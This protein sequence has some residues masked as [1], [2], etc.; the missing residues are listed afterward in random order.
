GWGDRL[1]LL[2][3][4]RDLPAFLGESSVQATPESSR[5]ALAYLVR[6][7]ILPRPR[8]AAPGISPAAGLGPKD[9][10]SPAAL[11]RGLHRMILRYEATGLHPAKYRGSRAGA[12]GMQTEG[13]LTFYPLA[14]R[15]HVF[16][17][18]ES[19][20]QPVADQVLQDGDNVEYHLS[21]DGAI[22]MLV[23]K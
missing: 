11:A 10:G 19:G 6:E 7:E 9:A 5:L 2:I 18:S 17:K 14:A 4:P 3:D 16:L 22:D 21:P 23:V 1:K 20:T 8:A 12:L 15:L 13:T